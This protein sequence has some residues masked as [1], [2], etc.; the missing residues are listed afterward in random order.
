MRPSAP[1]RIAYVPT[2]LHDIGPSTEA[3]T[4]NAL[5]PYLR[6]LRDHW[7]LVLAAVIVAVASSAAW[8]SV[9]SSR[10]EA[11]A[12]MLVTPVPADDRS[13]LGLP[14]L[15]E[16][17]GDPP[18]TIQTAV[19]L[20]KSVQAAEGVAR[21]VESRRTVAQVLDAISIQP[22]G[23]SNV[24]AVTATAD[25]AEGAARLSNQ[26]VASALFVRDAAIRTAASVQVDRIQARLASQGAERGTNTEALTAR[27]DVAQTL[28]ESDDPT[29]SLVQTARVPDAPV[30]PSKKLILLLAILAGF[31]IGSIGS[32]LSQILDRRIRDEQ[33]LTGLYPLAVLARVPVLTG[34]E[35]RRSAQ[36]AWSMPAPVR[37]AFRT[38]VVQ[39]ERSRTLLA[40]LENDSAG[41][42][43]LIT[44]ASAGDG[45]TRSAINLAGALAATGDRVI[46]LD[47]DLRKPEVGLMLDVLE[48]TRPQ[49]LMERQ[50]GL[51]DHLVPAPGLPSL[52]VMALAVHD[53]LGFLD[54]LNRRLP[55]LIEEARR[56][57]AWVVVD[58]APLGEVSDALSMLDV[59][60]DIVVVARP[61]NTELASLA[62]LRELLER[63]N[64]VPP[65][66]LLVV[67]STPRPRHYHHPHDPLPGAMPRLPRVG[68]LSE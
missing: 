67:T 52:S 53:D 28:R 47:L 18:R 49:A 6:A 15:R 25:S 7:L 57:A 5:A 33:E 29:I 59:V 65:A 11:A 12:Q 39:L 32:V 41:R 50:R 54:A 63:G 30:G 27:L 24:I 58:S 34:L 19:T 22:K 2:R 68:A 1:P 21:R 45:K 31:V 60:D 26:F 8:L 46:L 13:F 23:Q 20:I 17:P 40:G 4:A 35:R 61:G 55:E 36:S 56:L 62:T 14:V 37:E 66:G 38:L 16:S 44:S 3:P 9:R 42:V 51:A 48:Q 43:V 10:Y 64:I